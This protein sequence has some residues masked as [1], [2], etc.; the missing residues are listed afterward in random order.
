MPIR[1]V[2]DSACDLPPDLVAELDIDIVP[3]T[4]RFG[5]EEL[6]DGRDLSPKEFWARVASSPV[7]PETAAPSPGAF[8]EAFRRAAAGGADGVVCVNLSGA[9]SATFQSAS[10]A[11]RSVAD[12]IPVRVIDSRTVTMALGLMAVAA[13]RA[14]KQGKGLEDCAGVVEDLV[15]RTRTYGALDTMENLRKGGR[16][17][18]AQALLGSMLSIKP[19]IEVVDGLVEAESRQR[20]RSKS[21]R[22]LV[23]KV[24]GFGHVED[25]A[26]M[27]GD[28]PDLDELLDLLGAVYPRDDIL[29]GDIGPVI[30]THG[31]PRVIG[32]VFHV[33]R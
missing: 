15:P 7:L 28:A 4:I 14:A 24:R 12:D 31:G 29:V 19:I 30:G 32:V 16:I 9:L 20:T 26:V 5:N 27:H 33:P 8:E 22:Y 3:L 10:V 11:A 23:E 6:V 18:S 1:V 2:T 17:G 25:L 13:A 21:L